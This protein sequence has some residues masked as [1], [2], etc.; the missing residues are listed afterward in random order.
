MVIREHLSYNISTTARSHS[1]LQGGRSLELTQ[2][3]GAKGHMHRLQ[4]TLTGESAPH[5]KAA[6]GPLA[7]GSTEKE[8]SRLLC[9]NR[10]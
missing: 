3:D 8:E 4:S 2:L 9:A 7:E 1:G 5:T 6:G 10:A